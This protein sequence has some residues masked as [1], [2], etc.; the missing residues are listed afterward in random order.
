MPVGVV[1]VGGDST[2]G[3]VGIMNTG[4]NY[5][6]SHIGIGLGFVHPADAIRSVVNIQIQILVQEDAAAGIALIEYSLESF[7]VEVKSFHI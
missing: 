7:K 4:F 1:V 2:R 6:A 5:T 3:G